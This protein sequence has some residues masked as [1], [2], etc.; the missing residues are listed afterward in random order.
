MSFILTVGGSVV[1]GGL[2]GGCVISR[3]LV[4]IIEIETIYLI[5]VYS[6]WEVVLLGVQ[7]L[8][9]AS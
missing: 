3:R 1:G 8:E 5:F 2:G 9:E 6:P 4:L 7:L